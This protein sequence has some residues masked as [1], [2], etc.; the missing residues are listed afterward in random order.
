MDESQLR[1]KVLAGRKTERVV[2]AASEEMKAS[3][4]KIAEEKCMS[5]SALMTSL[6]TEEILA[7]KELFE[8]AKL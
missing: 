4:E 6:A 2:F 7:N 5:L 3:L 8:E 1:K